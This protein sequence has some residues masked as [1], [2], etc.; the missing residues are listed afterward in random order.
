[1]YLAAVDPIE[2]EPGKYRMTGSRAIAF[3]G[4]GPTLA[5]ANQHA[6]EACRR[7]RGPVRYRTDIGTAELIERRVRHM[8]RI[9]H[10]FAV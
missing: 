8:A 5:D 2:S 7:V 3:V 1:M 9:T 6:E 10:Q 4:I